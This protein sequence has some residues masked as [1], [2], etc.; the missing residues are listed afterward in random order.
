[1]CIELV[2]IITKKYEKGSTNR[3]TTSTTTYHVILEVNDKSPSGHSL[4]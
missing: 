1:M 3:Y 2:I 4:I